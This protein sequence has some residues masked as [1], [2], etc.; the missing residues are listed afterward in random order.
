MS[1]KEA[2]N[3]TQYGGPV[4]IVGTANL[5]SERVSCSVHPHEKLLQDSE[6]TTRTPLSAL[7]CLFA[8]IHL[9]SVQR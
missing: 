4:W 9:W 2:W 1:G 8:F 3:V 6:K 7:K 5:T